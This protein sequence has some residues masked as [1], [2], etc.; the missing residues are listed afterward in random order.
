MIPHFIVLLFLQI[1]FLLVG[2][3]RFW[4]IL[5]TG[6][7]PKWIFDYSVKLMRYKIRLNCSLLNLVDR[8]PSFG[9]NGKCDNIEYDVEYKTKYSRVR[10]ITRGLFGVIALFPHYIILLFQNIG[11]FFVNISSFWVILF[12]GKYPENSF[13]F[14]VGVKR[15]KLKL[16]NYLYYL[17][18][19]YPSFD[20]KSNI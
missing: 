16:K 4:S 1:G 6:S 19:K 15:H 11:V 20:N 8:Y 12:T 13:N 2:F 17:S 9:L 18:D 7:W 14:I 5:F 10:L 3:I